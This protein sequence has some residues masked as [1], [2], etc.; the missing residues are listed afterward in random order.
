MFT[1]VIKPLGQ[2]LTFDFCYF[3]IV[4]KDMVMQVLNIDKLKYFVFYEVNIIHVFE[5]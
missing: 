5:T 2:L 3:F 4:S 1:S